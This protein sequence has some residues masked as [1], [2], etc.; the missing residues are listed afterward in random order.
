[1]YP[2]ISRTCEIK[3]AV[4]EKTAYT[5]IS[6]HASTLPYRARQACPLI[7]EFLAYMLH[8]KNW[9]LVKLL[10]LLH[11]SLKLSLLWEKFSWKDVLHW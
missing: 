10:A 11:S 6:K 2:C 7:Y 5:D 3:D 8:T 9:I 1:M 4:P